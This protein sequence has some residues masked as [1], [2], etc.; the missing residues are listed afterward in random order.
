[1]KVYPYM[2]R[3]PEKEVKK[4]TV[5]K[6]HAFPKRT[7]ASFESQCDGTYHWVKY[8]RLA[9]M[10]TV[11]GLFLQCRRRMSAS[12]RR[13]VIRGCTN[14]GQTF[15]SPVVWNLIMSLNVRQILKLKAIQRHYADFRFSSCRLASIYHVGIAVV[16]FSK[17]G[18]ILLLF[19]HLAII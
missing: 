18:N 15:T 2:S 9:L 7:K 4:R 8:V 16:D 14:R 17:K 11:K 19:L 12:C 5:R 13:V 6:K 10:L 1:M 3:S